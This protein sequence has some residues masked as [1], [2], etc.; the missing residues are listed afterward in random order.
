MTLQ[1]EYNETYNY[2]P[3][4]QDIIRRVCIKKEEFSQIIIIRYG[5]GFIY[6]YFQNT[7]ENTIIFNETY[8]IKE[9]SDGRL[10]YIPY[11]KIFEIVMEK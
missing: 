2:P 10:L 3:M 4:I 1:L 11:N 7:D 6:D 5:S 9:S 8:L